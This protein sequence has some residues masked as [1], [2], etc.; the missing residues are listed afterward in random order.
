MTIERTNYNRNHIAKCDTCGK[1]ELY[2]STTIT[3]TARAMRAKG[4]SVGKRNGK[5]YNECP[6]CSN[7]DGSDCDN[8]PHPF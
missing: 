7:L 8:L 3:Y 2:R 6:R 1:T 4:W 5:W